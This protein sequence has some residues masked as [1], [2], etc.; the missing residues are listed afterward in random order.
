M[1]RHSPSMVGSPPTAMLTPLSAEVEPMV[2]AERPCAS[3]VERTSASLSGS[4]S[5]T[6]P[7]SSANSAANAPWGAVAFSGRS[8]YSRSS[9]RLQGVLR[10]QGSPVSADETKASLQRLP[11][12]WGQHLSAR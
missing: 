8:T 5:N 7:S 10:R 6:S 9:D 4:T 2:T 12:H 1:L 11:T 3:Y